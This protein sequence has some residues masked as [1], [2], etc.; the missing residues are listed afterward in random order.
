MSEANT[1]EIWQVEVNG[2]VYE[3][4][5]AELT[6]W[7][8]EGSLQPDDKVRRGNLRWIEAKKVPPLVAFFNA[9]VSGT[10]PPPVVVT[11]TAAPEPPPPASIV[12]P[13]PSII[14]PVASV[15]VPNQLRRTMLQGRPRRSHHL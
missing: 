6:A 4:D 7:I 14:V 5:F 10:P 1:Q 12:R 13:S 2:Q 11:M 9:K 15:N 3:A 8:A